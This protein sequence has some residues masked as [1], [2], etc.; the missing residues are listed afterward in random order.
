MAI[1][2]IETTP[3]HWLARLDDRGIERHLCALCG[4]SAELW[5][6]R[7]R[8][9][10]TAL[11]G[12]LSRFGSK[13]V[14]IAR[15]PGRV[16]LRGMHVDTH[17]GHFN[18]MTHQRET[19][20]V[21]ARANNGVCTYANADAGFPEFTFRPDA[22]PDP[23]GL[24]WEAFVGSSAV[25]AANTALSG[26]WERYIRGCAQ[27]LHARSEYPTPGLEA[28]VASDLPR[29]AALSASHALCVAALLAF[30]HAAGHPLSGRDRILAARDAEWYAGARTGTSDQAAMILGRKDTIV[31]GPLPPSDVDLSRLRLVSW[32]SE[33]VLV[34][35]Q[36]FTSRDLGGRE[37]LAYTANRFAYSLAIEILRDVLGATAESIQHLYQI[38]E[39]SLGRE[40]LLEA[41]LKIPERLTIDELR[42]RCCAAVVDEAYSQYF[43][44][45][46]PS[47]RPRS[48]PLRGP[49]LFGIMESKRARRFTEDLMAGDYATA[50]ALMTLGHAADRRIDSEG[51]PAAPRTDDAWIRRWESTR[52]PLT[53]IPGAYGASSP[54]LDTLVDAALDAGAYGASLT[55][56]G[57]AGVVV[58]LC[59]QASAPAVIGHVQKV[60]ASEH[61]A[62]VAGFAEPLPKEQ[63]QGGVLANC[64]PAGACVLG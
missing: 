17:G 57:I 39:E 28:F 4:Y 8:V 51:A 23:N 41:I 11:E 50:G 14:F 30:E 2:A 36:S 24:T 21:A 52:M 13:P 22:L 18:V 45:L 20:V 47:E 35:A 33:L 29:G 54:A 27:S 6:S 63:A 15:C 34:V 64:A 43:G 12:F 26:S 25:S 32:P 58:A 60:L 53:L 7:R 5:P 31:A 59:S 46:S 16:N 9:V 1:R 56:A 61:Y 49:L 62:R 48:I 44:T 38:S 40:G 10:V 19:V 42:S 37:R 55:G 3:E